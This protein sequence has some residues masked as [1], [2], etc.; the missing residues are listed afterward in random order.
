MLLLAMGVESRV[1]SLKIN[2][3]IDKKQTTLLELVVGGHSACFNYC[4]SSCYP[5]DFSWQAACMMTE[6]HL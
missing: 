4:L 3:Q 1:I 2:Y 6:H 5:T